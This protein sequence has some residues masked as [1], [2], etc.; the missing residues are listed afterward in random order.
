MPH[1]RP[2]NQEENAEWMSRARP[3]ARASEIVGSLMLGAGLYGILAAWIDPLG[4]LWLPIAWA[5]SIAGSLV[6]LRVFYGPLSPGVAPADGA[7]S[8][9][10]GTSS[11]GSRFFGVMADAPIERPARLEIDERDALD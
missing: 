5:L 3:G 1:V 2:W 9:K 10:P 11:L 4:E 8:T 6:F 7:V